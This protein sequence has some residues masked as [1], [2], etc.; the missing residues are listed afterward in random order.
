MRLDNLS[1]TPFAE[2]NAVLAELVR[3]LNTLLGD[4]LIGAY[5]QGSFAVGDFDER[6]DVD[7]MI[8][9][10]EDI[11]ES[12]LPALQALHAVIYERS[13]RWAQHLEGS[14][15]P[16]TV[17]RRWAETPRD[18]PGLPPRPSN[19]A[20]PGTSGSPPRVYPF[21]FL[22]NGA[23]VLVRSEHDNTRVVRW[24]TREKGIVL[25]GPSPREL[26][27][28]VSAEALCGE[29]REGLTTFAIP[30]L[31]DPAKMNKYWLQA[32]FVVLYCRML[33]TLATGEVA[34]KKA[35]TVWARTHLDSRWQ[36]LIERAWNQR[37]APLASWSQPANPL[38]VTETLAFMR[39]ALEYARDV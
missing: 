29:V 25:T 4:N 36:A 2:L 11:T 38:E 37:V 9:T 1:P 18:P 7:F 17:L 13:S 32:F 5:L 34:S 31:A 16:A 35:G 8:V 21:L 19:W 10:R 22:D 15:A 28:P 24:V 14:Y 12:N 3:A 26:I 33:H 20:D 27:D 30:W 23:N 39:Y 6:S